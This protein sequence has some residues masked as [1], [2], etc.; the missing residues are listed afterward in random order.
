[1]NSTDYNKETPMATNVSMVDLPWHDGT[2]R[3]R[4]RMD[5]LRGGARLHSREV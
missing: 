3:I 1:M 2:K 5:R 4:P